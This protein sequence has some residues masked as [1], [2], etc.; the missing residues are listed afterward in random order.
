[1]ALG[2]GAGGK[3]GFGGGAI[4]GGGGGA[5]ALVDA[6]GGHLLVLLLLPRL[7]PRSRIPLLTV[8]SASVIP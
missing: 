1:M 8:P 6:R 2:C 3:E 4:S 7:P 5:A